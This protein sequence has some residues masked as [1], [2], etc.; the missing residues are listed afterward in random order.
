MTNTERPAVCRYC[1]TYT[2][3]AKGYDT[4]EPRTGQTAQDFHAS[5]A[6][7]EAIEPSY[8]NGGPA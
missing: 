7:V 1:G 3:V 6:C 2:Y 8:R 5:A 4:N